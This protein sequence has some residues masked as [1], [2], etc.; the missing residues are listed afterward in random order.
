MLAFK[1]NKGVFP[2]KMSYPFPIPLNFLLT[3]RDD[4]VKLHVVR[5]TLEV[6][7]KLH[8]FMAIQRGKKSFRRKNSSPVILSIEGNGTSCKLALKIYLFLCTVY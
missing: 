2:C 5:M 7:K 4:N 6:F 1:L 3:I 8:E